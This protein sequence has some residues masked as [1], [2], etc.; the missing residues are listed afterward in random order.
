M[1]EPSR[2]Y[3][4][5]MRIPQSITDTSDRVGIHASRFKRVENRN[6][7]WLLLLALALVS[8]MG[9]QKERPDIIVVYS[10]RWRV[11]RIS[12]HGKCRTG[13]GFGSAFTS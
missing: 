7:G 3:M 5:G 12:E 11:H 13:S 8:K 4:R 10:L 1:L 9:A 6:Q 2:R